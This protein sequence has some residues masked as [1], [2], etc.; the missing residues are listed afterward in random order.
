MGSISGL[1]R[2]P[3]GGNGN[4]LQYF[5][6]EK[7]HGQRILVDCSPYSCKELDTTE[8]LTTHTDTQTHTHTHTHTKGPCLS[9]PLW[10]P[11]V[12]RCSHPVGHSCCR[13]DRSRASGM[14]TLPIANATSL[15][16]G[17]LHP[18]QSFPQ[19]WS[20]P[21]L[22]PDGEEPSLTMLCSSIKSC[23]FLLKHL[24]HYD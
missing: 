9:S 1:G 8:Q 15:R 18:P 5:S 7:S 4:P 21:S 14:S 16:E 10:S 11:L 17:Q 12:T 2:S 19:I 13:L 3:G 24:L 6:W 22:Q 23:H 20:H